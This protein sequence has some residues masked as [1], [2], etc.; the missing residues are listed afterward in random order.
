MS[1][2][3]AKDGEIQLLVPRTNHPYCFFGS[4]YNGQG[5]KTVSLSNI[6]HLF[7]FPSNFLC[8]DNFDSF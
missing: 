5:L 7:I 1:G 2:L 3:D 4:K 8:Q 6:G